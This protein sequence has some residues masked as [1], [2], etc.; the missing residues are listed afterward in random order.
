MKSDSCQERDPESDG[1]GPET[2]QPLEGGTP[3][4]LRGHHVVQWVLGVRQDPMLPFHSNTSIDGTWCCCLSL[5]DLC[6]SPCY[7]VQSLRVCLLGAAEV[8]HLIVEHGTLDDG[9][10]EASQDLLVNLE[11]FH[12]S[13]QVYALVRFVTA[14][15]NVWRPVSLVVDDG[16]QVLVVRDY[17]YWLAPDDDRVH[18]DRRSSEVDDEFFGLGHVQLQV[19][20][21]APLSQLLHGLSV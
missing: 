18:I 4:D 11:L 9:L 10:V 6:R 5:H 19:V 14:C 1:P 12:F 2:P 15:L 17:F 16:A 7:L 20:P 8:A 21:V 13:E 3:A